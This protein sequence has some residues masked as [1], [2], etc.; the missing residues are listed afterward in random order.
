VSYKCRGWDKEDLKLAYSLNRLI[1]GQKANAMFKFVFIKNA[2]SAS[3]VISN[4]RVIINKLAKN[5]M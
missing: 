3:E 1:H 5:Q 4:N 2:I